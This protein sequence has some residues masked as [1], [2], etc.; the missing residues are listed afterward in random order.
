MLIAHGLLPGHVLQRTPKGASVTVTG[1]TNPPLAGAVT[2][3][4]RKGRKAIPGFTGKRVGAAADGVFQATLKGLP[5]GGPYTV[6]FACGAQRVSVDEVFVGDLWLMAGQSNMQGC[7]N[8][9]DA[10]APHLLIRNFTMAR[11]WELARDPL[12]FLEESPDPVHALVLLSPERAARLKRQAIKGAGVGVWFGKEMHRRTR[13][14]QG[15]IA[16]AHGGTTMAQWDPA[17]AG[18]NGK[19]LYGSMLLS[20]RAVGQPIAGVLWYQ[21]CSDADP[22][23]AAVYTGRMQALVAAGRRDLKQPKLPWVIAQIS[24]VVETRPDGGAAWNSVQDQQR[25]LPTTIPRCDVVATIDLELDDQVHVSGKAFA[26]LGL[27]MARVAARLVHGDR[28]E[29]PAP[30][31]VSAQAHLFKGQT[32]AAIAVRFANVV[33]GLVAPGLPLGFAVVDG[34]GKRADL[35]YKTELDGDRAIVHLNA[36]DAVGYRIA[37]GFGNNPT[38]TIT[39][40]RGMALPVCAPL[41][42]G[43]LPA[44]SPWFITWNVTP[45]RPGE[46]ILALPRPAA[47]E[48]LAVAR[49]YVCLPY[50]YFIDNHEDWTGKS[51]HAS[52]TSVVEVPEAMEVEVRTGYDGPFRLWIGSREVHTDPDGTNPATRDQHRI[53]LRLEAGRHPVAI[54]MAIN[55]GMAWGFFFRIA[56]VGKDVKPGAKVPVPG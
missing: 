44:V 54:L 28:G 51:G 13:V 10:P 9:V 18:E 47:D 31:P 5:T 3:T 19:S 25:R 6:E 7:G 55:Q 50:P 11:R 39:D 37:Y 8:L 49:T 16:T 43:R 45:V 15:L 30:Q 52:F 14:P 46:D 40:G 22:A 20:L 23:A 32:T 24:R 56:R 27:R 17:L 26:T 53:R 29:K 48:P 41:A 2:A 1:V 35:I 33:G 38:C 12:N 36:P 42:I 34:D 4:V 21:G